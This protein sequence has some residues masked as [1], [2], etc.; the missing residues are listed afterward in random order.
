MNLQSNINISKITIACAWVSVISAN[1]IVYISASNM[2]T[3]Y[4]KA[5]YHYQMK[6]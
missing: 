2:I 6:I 4:L 1:A 3:D 5:L